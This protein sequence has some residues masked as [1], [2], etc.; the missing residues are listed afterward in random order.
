[1]AKLAY[2]SATFPELKGKYSQREG[3]GEG[4]NSKAAISRAVGSLLKSVNRKHFTTI[5]CKVTVITKQ[6]E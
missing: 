2:I 1:M 3:R 4:S 5:L 6:E